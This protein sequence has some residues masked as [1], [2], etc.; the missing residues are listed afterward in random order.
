MTKDGRP[1]LITD[2]RLFA[3]ERYNSAP[4]LEGQEE[5]V[6][7]GRRIAWLLNSE[8]FSLGAFPALYVLFT[9][10]LEPGSV[11]FP[12]EGGDWWQRYVYIGVTADFP[13]APDKRDIVMRGI[14]DAILATRPD[15]EGVIRRADAIVREHGDRLR[16]L[17]KRRDLAKL[18][19]EISFNIEVS[20]KPSYLFIG[21]TDKENGAYTE[22]EPIALGWYMEG[23]DLLSGIRLQDAVNLTQRPRPAMTSEVKRRG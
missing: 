4:Y 17:L 5:A 20:S 8:G 9:P 14:A 12:N 6:A 3:G 22:A 7:Y 11:K 16:F 21:H 19:V 10:L 1:S 2:I 13:D 18:V 23:F 15:Q